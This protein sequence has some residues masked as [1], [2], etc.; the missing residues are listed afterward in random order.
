MALES[1]IRA[2]G[3][4][5]HPLFILLITVI[6][7]I[8]SLVFSYMLFP[9]YT[10]VL[11]VAFITIGLVPII[12]RILVIEE[13]EE[14]CCD[15]SVATFF[16]RHFNVI[17]I[18]IWIFV[19]VI[20]TFAL[21]YMLV[22]TGMKTEMFSEQIR[23]FCIISGECVSNVPLSITGNASAFAFDA[24]KNPAVSTL[25]SCSFFIFENN[26]G[27]MFLTIILSLL[28]GA[29]AIFIVAWNASILGV[30][31]G[32]MLLV[33]NHG[34][35]LGLLQGM[36]I[37][38][39]PPELLGYIFAALSGAILS[40]VV[41]KNKLAPHEL[42]KVSEDVLFLIFLAIFSVAYGAVLEAAGMLGMELFYSFGGFFYVL[43]L[44]LAVIFYG[45]RP[46]PEEIKK[47]MKSTK[48]KRG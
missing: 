4:R 17:Q 38:H 46:S 45:R 39:G 5:K 37:G 22:P 13:E 30:F 3:I 26:I 43:V 44:M 31:F 20:L 33:A 21:V 25:E 32:E 9:K 24:C 34:K 16:A 1:L 14:A 27:V 47:K 23:T 18:Y 7:T 2:K 19:G 28:Y 41:A 8:G 35:G 48:P 11:S 29:G 10:S 12:Y 42:A 40:A 36:L 6:A 15:K